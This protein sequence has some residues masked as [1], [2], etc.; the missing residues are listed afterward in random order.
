MWKNMTLILHFIGLLAALALSFASAGMETALYRASRIRM[1]IRADRGEP[2]AKLLLRVL[3]Q[4]DSMVAAILL[5]SNLAAYVG[6]YF[7][8]VQLVG[9]K[10]PHTE[11]VATAVI[12]PLFFILTESLPKQIAYNNADRFAL[13]FVRLFDWTRRLFMPF[14]WLLTNTSRVLRKMLKSDREPSLSQSQRTLL[15]EHL[16]AGV[17]EEVLTEEQNSMAVRIMQLEGIDAEDCMV[18]LRKLV[19][20]PE[21]APRERALTELAKH[22][23]EIALLVDAAGRVTAR[24][25]TMASLVIEEGRTGESVDGIA[26]TLERIR[27]GVA[28]PAVLNLFREKHARCALVVQG[29]RVVGLITTKS[30]LDCIAGIS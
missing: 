15:M 3:D 10:V 14:V 26:E 16:N 23:Q 22:R 25:V 20:L 5:D 1:R 24:A 9:W 4:L 18:P 12:T 29:N 28:I 13:R 11:L 27:I 17:A 8:T 6:T 2:R 21:N 7:L 19:L 30:V